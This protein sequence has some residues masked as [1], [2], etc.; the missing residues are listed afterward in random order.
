M[1]IVVCTLALTT[2]C[3]SRTLPP[4][5]AVPPDAAPSP[6]PAPDVIAPTE[7]DTTDRSA[8]A[9]VAAPAACLLG[10]EDGEPIE[11]IGLIDTVDAANA[12]HPVNAS[13]ELL[14]RQ[15]YES[16]LRIDCEGQPR[17]ALAESWQVEPD[18]TWTLTVRADA[19]FTDG[20]F[21]TTDAVVTAWTGG[22][23]GNP[24]ARAR[25]HIL[26]A[27]ALDARRIGVR[28]HEGV[29]APA[30]FASPDLAVFR[31]VPGQTWPVGTRAFRPES[32]SVSAAVTGRTRL[33][34]VRQP[35]VSVAPDGPLTPQRSIQLL[36]APNADP[37]DLL[38]EGVDLLVT[39]NP[40][41]VDYAATLAH[42]ETVPLAWDMTHVLVSRTTGPVQPLS[43][44]ERDA[45]ARDAVR[46]EARGAPSTWLEDIAA[47]QALAQPPRPA[48][49]PAMRRI[50]F[51]A[52]D[53]TARDLA[54]RIVGLAATRSPSAAAMLDGLL[55]RSHQ[56]L[57]RAIGLTGQALASALK[58][59]SDAGYVLAFARTAVNPCDVVDSV[60]PQ[61]PWL[62][63]Q[64]VVPLVETRARAII[65]RGRS[66][67]VHE[68]EGAI[69][70]DV[71]ALDRRRPE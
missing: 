41:A 71:S 9:P 37:R 30:A 43:A 46:G 21:V 29:S 26:S 38:D 24:D 1:A 52:A 60:L 51:D 12:P 59:G 19:R 44:D 5:V 55:P 18:G 64:A 16:P 32:D 54:E 25:R 47:C 65:R 33:T 56:S 57:Q 20:V 48:V 17:P 35:P 49:S 63:P 62:D 6:G 22:A 31:H 10:S 7:A 8:A 40:R 53:D 15:L 66:G 50:V 58:S 45:L 42:F 36:I 34:L 69:V 4:P 67:L 27:A 13:E 3:G 70:I 14:F 28:L 68:G 11:S 61:I 2:A 23:T 39:R